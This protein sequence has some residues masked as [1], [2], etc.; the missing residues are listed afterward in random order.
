MRIIEYFNRSIRAK[1]VGVF[2]ALLLLIVLIGVIYFPQKLKNRSIESAELQ[3][4]TLSEMLAFSVGAGINDGNFNI[5]SAALDWAKNDKDVT[6]ISVL[7][8]DSEVLIE[9]NPNGITVGSPD[10][11]V[12]GY[13]ADNGY[14]ITVKDIDYEGNNFGKIVLFY[15]LESIITEVNSE[16]FFATIGGFIILAFGMAIVFFITNMITGQI[17]KLRNA[18]TAASSGDLSVK[19]ESNTKD[20]IGDLSLA[21]SKMLESISISK[22]ALEEEKN[23][24]EKKVEEAVHKSEKQHE[25]LAESTRKM[26]E[27]MNRFQK[28]DLTISLLADK[29]D[30]I[31]QLF[32][33]FNFAVDNIREM[34]V[35]V[36]QAVQK[37]SVSTQD[38]SSTTNILAENAQRQGEQTS[39]VASA[40]EEMT[41]T[42][43]ETNQNT[44]TAAESAK[45]SGE[46]AHKGGDVV[47]Q[48]VEGMNKTAEVVAQAA[49]TVGDL[50]ES[51]KQIGEIIQVIDDIADQTNLLALNAAIEA[52][53]AGEQGRGFA[54]VADEVRK[55]AERTTKATKEISEMIKKIQIETASSVESINQGKEE[56]E[57]GTKLASEAGHSLQEIIDSSTSVVELIAQVAVASAEQSTAAEDIG[58]SIE[59]INNVTA[60][61]VNSI[62]EVA[63]SVEGLRNLTDE[64]Q[65]LVNRFTI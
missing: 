3:V 53:R 41:N 56:A 30:D 28:G 62:H 15:S 20:E 65:E 61:S 50:G 19:I 29:D 25:Y 32:T 37:T 9:H 17:I 14:Y 59:T 43:F 51:S 46:V 40:V 33:G 8:E 39:E 31:G 2:S 36:S 52:A 35:S 22:N 45:T 64:L 38:I 23:S 34:V 57:N 55:L 5:V 47:E 21:F 48:A 11:L 58:K 6:V 1:L 49:K 7:D 60:D 27:A 63:S 4:E 42:I 16:R 44:N 54:V 10:N 12:S 18:A 13:N 26:L 24:V